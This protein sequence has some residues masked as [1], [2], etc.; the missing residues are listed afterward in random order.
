MTCK[1]PAIQQS[2][3]ATRTSGPGRPPAALSGTP[4]QSP[5]SMRHRPLPLPGRPSPGRRGV[6]LRRWPQERPARRVPGG[7]GGGGWLDHL[8]LGWL[9]GG[10]G[11]RTAANSGTGPSQMEYMPTSKTVWC[12][13]LK[14]MG[15]WCAFH[16]CH[17]QTRKMTSDRRRLC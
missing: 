14:K 17:F 6:G 10:S 3:L 11:R 4:L 7:Q 8:V 12:W 15:V 2:A 1:M 5:F 9:P 13:E 16:V